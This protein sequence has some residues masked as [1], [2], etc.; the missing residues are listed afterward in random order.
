LFALEIK[1]LAGGPF[2]ERALLL[3]SNGSAHS[4]YSIG[5]QAEQICRSVFILITVLDSEYW[6]E[7]T[8]SLIFRSEKKKWI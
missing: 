6:P 1:L 8:S 4:I 5:K 3:D 7:I 2:G